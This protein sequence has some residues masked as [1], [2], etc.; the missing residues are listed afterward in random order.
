MN[1]IVLTKEDELCIVGCLENEDGTFQV[2]TRY[3][4]ILKNKIRIETA[5]PE[6][7]FPSRE[8]AQKRMR[9]IVKLKKNRKGF[10]NFEFELAYSL[11]G[12]LFPENVIPQSEML[13][14]VEE[15]KNERIVVLSDITGIS[16]WFQEGVEYLAIDKDPEGDCIYVYDMF[17][18]LRAVLRSRMKSIV[19]SEE[20][21]EFFSMNPEENPDLFA[22]TEQEKELVQ[23]NFLDAVRSYWK[24]L[25]SQ[26]VSLKDAKKKCEEYRDANPLPKKE[27]DFDS[28][29]LTEEEKKLVDSNRKITAIKSLRK[30][31]MWSLKKAKRKVDEYANIP[32]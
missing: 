25:K 7:E 19:L 27:A 1:N 8:K 20:A 2:A 5:S 6:D 16:S 14:M 32:F 21:Q 9:K 12:F 10:D 22:L 26:G 18:D 30:R 11:K 15:V 17:G 13:Q 31:T 23:Q 28:I 3:V 4:D 24:R 29:V